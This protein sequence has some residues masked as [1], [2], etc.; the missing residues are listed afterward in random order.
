MRRLLS[1]TLI[2]LGVLMLSAA[3]GVVGL[4]LL[5][6]P[7]PQ[8]FPSDTAR[9]LYGSVGGS[10]LGIPYPIFMVLPRIFPDLIARYAA[11]G[12]GPDKVGWG[13]WGAFGFAWEQGQRLPA[14]FSID[15]RG[16]ERVTVTC[17]LCHTATWR[18]DEADVPNI[19]PGGPANTADIAAFAKFLTAAASDRR[20]TSTRLMPEV[21]LNF[22][23][24]WAEAKLYAWVLIPATRFALL[25]AGEQLAWMDSRPV[26]GPGRDDAF[27]LPKFILLREAWDDTIG[28]TDF[29]G[30]WRMGD[31][32]GMRLHAGGEAA[33]VYGVTATS[34]LGV[35]SL[36]VIGFRARNDWVVAFLRDLPPP[37]YPFAVDPVQAQE[38]R[39]IFGA[40]CAECHAGGGA[41]TGTVIPLDEIGTDPEHV[42]TWGDKDARRMN[43]LT[44]A[45]GIS[46]AA[47]SGAHG[48]V[49]RPLPGLWLLGPYLHNG[50]VPT[51]DDLLQPP[52]LRPVVFWRGYDVLDVG[53]GGFVASGP[54]AER[55]GFRFDTR[56]RGNGN[57]GHRYGTDLD[58]PSRS[59]L[60]A[61]LK[62][63]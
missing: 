20:F 23:M 55:A 32:Q 14:G 42:R 57:G 60:I 5:L 59:A 46:D 24:N 12:Y 26:W 9:F 16:Y 28:T 36:P 11:L 25:A 56:L 4:I 53:R 6:R 62:T 63:L 30:L 2:V 31:R 27:N 38:G 49:A 45:L 48:Y 43:R 50:S 17:A 22:P 21:L 61:Y 44:S 18:A 33:S 35:G 37:P 3:A 51:L 54:A 19:V 15:A 8:S 7:G 10:A 40:R 1:I 41:R 58:P 13:G 29:P 47:M 39:A 52:E 34:A